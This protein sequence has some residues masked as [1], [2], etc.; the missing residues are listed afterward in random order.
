MR[1]KEIRGFAI[2]PQFQGLVNHIN[3]FDLSNDLDIKAADHEELKLRKKLVSLEA[4]LVELKKESKSI[5]EKL[6][7][8]ST[9]LKRKTSIKS[10]PTNSS[11]FPPTPESEASDLDPLDPQNLSPNLL[12]INRDK[13]LRPIEKRR[14]VESR[15]KSVYQEIQDVCE[16]H[17]ESIGNI[18]GHRILAEDESACNA[19]DELVDVVS[20]KKGIKGALEEVFSEDKWMTYL[21]TMRQ[22]DWTLLYFKLAAKI[23]DEAWQTLLNITQLGRSGVST[24][25]LIV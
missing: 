2:T 15:T 1:Q 24:V 21:K 4:Q 3:E 22:P 7:V 16:C 17:R 5:K 13:K 11:I 19:L 10:A 9:A 20:E 6:E 8:G 25:K 23:P 18:I 14:N 12:E